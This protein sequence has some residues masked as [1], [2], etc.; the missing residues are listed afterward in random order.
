MW[1]IIP[2]LLV[3]IIILSLVLPRLWE[4]LCFLYFFTIAGAVGLLIA[5]I[6]C[7]ANYYET[8]NTAWGAE[9]YYEQII[10]PNVVAEGEDYVVVENIEAAVWQAGDYTVYNYNSYLV[11]TKHWQQVP[12]IG[13]CIYPVP[14]HLKYVR[15]GK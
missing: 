15:I 10:L 14:E 13:T 4:P 6:V 12:I 7:P 2:S 8:R 11:T 1:W 9:Q 5:V 3:L